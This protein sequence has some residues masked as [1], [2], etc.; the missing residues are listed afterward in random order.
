MLS[1]ISLLARI[2][3]GELVSL[4]ELFPLG[5]IALSELLSL[6][7]MIRDVIS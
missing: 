4:S 5:G 2:A 1:E 7:E 6:S 3:F